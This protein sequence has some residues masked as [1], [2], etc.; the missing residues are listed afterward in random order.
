MS[1]V[2]PMPNKIET[3]LKTTPEMRRTIAGTP[4][5]SW[6]FPEIVAWTENDFDEANRIYDQLHPEEVA[7]D[8]VLAKE[9][10]E[11]TA[12]EI[13]N[14]YSEAI[15]K[16][17]GSSSNA[18]RAYTTSDVIANANKPLSNDTLAE[19]T[20]SYG[21]MNQEEEAAAVRN[22]RIAK[23]AELDNR[24][25][26]IEAKLAEASKPIAKKGLT[27]DQLQRKIAAAQMRKFKGSD[28]TSFW[29][30][31]VGRKDAIK[32][33]AADEAKLKAEKELAEDK[34]RKTNS[35]KTVAQL[36]KMSLDE[37]TTRDDIKGWMNQLAT[38]EGE[39][40][41][42]GDNELL[43]KIQ[44]KR[45]EIT[46]GGFK[47][48]TERAQ[49]ILAEFTRIQSQTGK[50]GGYTRKQA[51]EQITALAEKNKD[52]LMKHAPDLYLQLIKGIGSNSSNK[53][54]EDGFTFGEKKR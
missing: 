5:A 42:Y 48:A 37:Y 51:K 19:D 24:I 20:R 8:E 50:V 15:G 36:D 2:Y 35:F 6:S 53:P 14:G 23:I 41:A 43:A 11:A 27:E 3:E 7:A 52:F 32:K 16:R 49:D 44:A 47:P 38:L 26:E 29:R 1:F 9:N 21:N 17:T 30:W 31:E 25:M 13:M 12:N 34:V 33:Q 45:N 28:P 39:A 10:G 4:D 22:S 46:R 40:A 18:H 54:N